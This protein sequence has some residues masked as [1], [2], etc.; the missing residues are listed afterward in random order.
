MKGA[1]AV[2]CF[3][4][5]VMTTSLCL[6]APACDKYFTPEFY[7]IGRGWIDGLINKKKGYWLK[8]LPKKGS[9]HRTIVFTMYSV[10]EKYHKNAD[11][12]RETGTKDLPLYV[13]VDLKCDSI[14]DQNSYFLLREAGFSNNPYSGFQNPSPSWK[15]VTPKKTN[16]MIE[17]VGVMGCM[18]SIAMER[19][20][21]IF[22]DD[23]SYYAPKHGHFTYEAHR[24]S[25]VKL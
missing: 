11:L 1:I 10:L 24:C 4:G 8:I 12:F 19:E 21:T 18:Y 6:P 17:W 16:N 14:M 15:R 13:K 23:D 7:P 22:Y 5:L 25:R 2:K 9:S 20:N 3:A